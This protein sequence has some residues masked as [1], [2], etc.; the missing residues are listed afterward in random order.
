M[1]PAPSRQRRRLLRSPMPLRR[2]ARRRPRRR[3][4]PR[5]LIPPRV[6]G[7]PGTPHLWVPPS[8]TPPRHRAP[9]A[10]HPGKG[11][12]DV[13]YQCRDDIRAGIR[14]V[15]H[16]GPERLP[17]AAMWVGRTSRTSG[18]PNPTMPK[19]LLKIREPSVRTTTPVIFPPA[20]CLLTS[21]AVNL[22]RSPI[23]PCRGHASAA[24]PRPS[25]HEQHRRGRVLTRLLSACASANRAD[26]ESRPG[27]H[28]RMLM[29][30]AMTR[31]T[32]I[33]ET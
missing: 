23:S 14:R 4:L 32:V 15:G 9:V 1:N 7:M 5:S 6:T 16:T 22:H 3:L 19:S 11:P 12:T 18:D 13:R 17:T 25:E 26:R 21:L 10:T 29:A 24:E 8:T 30:R 31:A 33:S 2:C 27:C 28:L 20:S